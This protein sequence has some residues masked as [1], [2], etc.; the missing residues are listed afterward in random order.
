M[1]VMEYRYNY[2]ESEWIHTYSGIAY[3]TLEISIANYRS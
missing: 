3:K 1:E 2:I